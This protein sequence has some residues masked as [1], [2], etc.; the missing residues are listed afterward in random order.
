M[1]SLNSYFGA[2]RTAGQILANIKGK[3]LLSKEAYKGKAE[4]Q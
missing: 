4:H 1:D 2:K 3:E